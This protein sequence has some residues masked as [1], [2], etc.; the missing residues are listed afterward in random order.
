MSDAG[1][2]GAFDE[3]TRGVPGPLPGGVEAPILRRLGLRP[4]TTTTPFVWSPTA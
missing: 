3:R 1:W 4:V 2:P